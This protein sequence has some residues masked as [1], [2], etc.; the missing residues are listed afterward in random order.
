[1]STL[2]WTRKSRVQFAAAIVKDGWTLSSAH[3]GRLPPDLGYTLQ[4][5]RKSA[6]DAAHPDCVEQYEHIHPT[7]E[8]SLAGKRPA[9]SVPVD[10]KT[11]WPCGGG[12]CFHARE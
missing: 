2:S 1:M 3:V 12:E 5:T 9:V 6:E 8:N 7:A 4:S 10:T 11:G